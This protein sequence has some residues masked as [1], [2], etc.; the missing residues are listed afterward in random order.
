[1]AAPLKVTWDLMNFDMHCS[2]RGCV[3]ILY[4]FSLLNSTC[5][6]SRGLT[7]VG[8]HVLQ[9]VVVELELDATGTTSVGF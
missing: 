6:C 8:L 7:S 5:I 3:H 9:Q 4:L 2:H 1:M